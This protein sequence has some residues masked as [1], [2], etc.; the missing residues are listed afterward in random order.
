MLGVDFI[1]D[2]LASEGI[3]HVFMVPGGLIDPFL[4]ALGRQSAIKPIVAAQ[5]GGAAYMADGYARASGKPGIA[6]CIGGPG[7]TNTV[8]AV[9]TAKTD[10]TALLVL[11]GEAATAY[12]GLGMFQDASA[13]TLDDVS[14]LKPVTRYSTSIDNPEN[15]AH[16][17]R[18]ALIR[19][20]TE[21]TGPV[22]ISIP[23]DSQVATIDARHQPL[24][25]ALTHP[26]V[27]SLSSA[28]ASLRHFKTGEDGK[29]PAR[30][31]I[32]AGAGVEHADA[33]Q[34]LLHFAE[35]WDVPVA[36]TL[37]AK[38]IFPE[39]HPLSLGVFG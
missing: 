34:A 4:P 35:A 9:A 36:T 37:R 14:L 6:L 8:T 39:N 5:E 21:P 31:V 16:L 19:L 13:Q 28:E 30:I 38:G 32:L 26:K 2:G 25:P 22:H 18:H 3:D 10:G 11:S 24:D 20:R 1:L 33:A 17:F 23:N 12:E 7:L 29:A 15:L 27:L